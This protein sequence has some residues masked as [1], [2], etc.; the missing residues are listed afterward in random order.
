MTSEK[1]S[2]IKKLREAREGKIKRTDQ[3]EVQEMNNIFEE[4]SPEE[5]ERI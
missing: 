4:I 5:Y 2:A 1:K 3:Y